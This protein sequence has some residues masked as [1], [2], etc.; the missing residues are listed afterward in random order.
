MAIRAGDHGVPLTAIPEKRVSDYETLSGL[1]QFAPSS[2]DR[3]RK[4][5]IVNGEMAE[6]S[7]AHA[8]KRAP[9]ERDARLS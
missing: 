2:S 3:S 9:G 8:G 7:M 6:W 4:S 1:T 5:L